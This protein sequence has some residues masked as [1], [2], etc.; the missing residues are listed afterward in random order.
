VPFDVSVSDVLVAVL[1]LV[2]P[3]D[4]PKSFV[5]E[6]Y[7]RNGKRRLRE[8]YLPTVQTDEDWAPRLLENAE[9]ALS[10]EPP[11]VAVGGSSELAV[12]AFDDDPERLPLP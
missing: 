10:A 7:D 11:R 2:Q 3:D 5:I 6:L 8:T 12:W 4:G 9:L 1:L